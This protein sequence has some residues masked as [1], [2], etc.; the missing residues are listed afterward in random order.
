MPQTFIFA[1]AESKEAINSYYYQRTASPRSFESTYFPRENRPS[2]LGSEPLLRDR[3]QL[4]LEAPR[5]AS[6]PVIECFGRYRKQ[7]KN[8]N[9]HCSTAGLKVSINPLACFSLI[10][11]ERGFSL[12]FWIYG[13]HLVMESVQL[14]V[15]SLPRGWIRSWFNSRSLFLFITRSLIPR[16]K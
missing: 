15:I 4:V 8:E 11:P 9:F 3:L 5:K 14:D 2:L 16:Q 10:V 7:E 13:V 1:K 6:N 12:L